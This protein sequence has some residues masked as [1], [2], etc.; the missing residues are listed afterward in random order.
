VSATGASAE[1]GR[2][3]PAHVPELDGVRAVAVLAVLALHIGYG[4]VS[5]GSLGVDLFFVL[6]GYLI[7]G[8]LVRTLETDGPRGLFPFYGRRI[9][10]LYPALVIAVLLA[11][12]LWAFGAENDGPWEATLLPVA[13][14]YANYVDPSTLG[15]LIATWSLSVEEQFYV[16]W[17]LVLIL[18]LPR[19]RRAVGAALVVAIVVAVISRWLHF[20][21]NYR[22][23]AYAFTQA[24]LDGLA[25][26]GLVA[27]F[28]EAAIKASPAV[29]RRAGDVGFAT[30]AVFSVLVF[31]CGRLATWLFYGGFTLVAFLSG[32][33]ILCA[34]AA[35]PDTSFRRLLR[36]P[37]LGWF[38][39]RSYGLYLFHLPIFAALEAFRRAGSLPNFVWVTTLRFAAVCAFA[40]LSYR[41]VER[42]IREGARR[43]ADRRRARVVTA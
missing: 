1:T 29:V 16:V 33:L 43:Y 17:P 26:G 4:H 15:T 10:R 3:A 11:G 5:G 31:F 27:L 22:W 14:Y 32:V 20:Q 34:L 25:V 21:P 18:L 23:S 42:P 9:G 28:G 12:A 13:F 24:R 19:G 37:A 2:G 8:I 35:R 30:L 6:S 41:L 36:L 38:G 7:T 40:E 39:T